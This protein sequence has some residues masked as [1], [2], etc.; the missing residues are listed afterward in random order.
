MEQFQISKIVSS[1]C[2]AVAA[3]A[4]GLWPEESLEELFKDFN[5]LLHSEKDL[6]LVGKINMD[7]YLGFAHISLRQ[8]YTEGSLFKPVAYVEGIFV[9]KEYRKQGYGSQFIN[10]AERWALAK[11]C[12]EIASD[13][14]ITNHNSKQFHLKNGFRESNRIIT[15]IKTIKK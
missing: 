11:N 7:D 2:K 10:E 14:E 1:D 12:R 13:T 3:M 15:F 9:K 8:E 4:K 6:I 5:S